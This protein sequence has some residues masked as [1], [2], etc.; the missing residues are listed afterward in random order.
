M[1]A[2][3]LSMIQPSRISV[4]RALIAQAAQGRW[5]IKCTRFN[6]DER[7]NGQACYVVDAGGWTFSFPI[8]SSEPKTAGRSAR[9]IGTTWDML[10]ALIEG[11]ITDDDFENTGRELPKLYEGRATPTTLVW[12]RSNRSG[13]LFEQAIDAL[14]E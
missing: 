10:G 12:A 2:E 11:R 1:K 7:G 4:S 9:I 13:R 5:K 8:F 14:A 3:S 6:L